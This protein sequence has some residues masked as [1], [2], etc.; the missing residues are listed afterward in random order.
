[1]TM[2]DLEGQ[3]RQ[4][5]KR[6][7]SMDAMRSADI[8]ELE[9]HV[10]DSMAALTSR[11]LDP[12]EAFVVATHRVGAPAAVE[13]EFAKVN[14]SHL[15][16]QRVFWMAAGALGYTVGGLVIAALASVSQ[17]AVSLAGARGTAA[18]FT[19]VG[20]TCL[21]WIVLAAWLYPRRSAQ[22]QSPPLTHL[23]A[24]M[25]GSIVALAV[26]VATLMNVGSRLVLPTVMP[27]TE[28]TQ[29]MLIS[30]AA[31]IMSTVLMPLALLIVMLMM[32]RRM[33]GTRAIGQ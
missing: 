28:L 30:N 24:R 25:I 20:I 15:W 8:E 2:F 10:R 22:S 9:Q 33:R 3:L 32:G 12:E 5:K 18:G 13:R 11:G 19:A 14:E 6:F 16:S 26:V 17:V 7:T 29:A 4:W 21:G 27:I 23:P 1:M 31:T